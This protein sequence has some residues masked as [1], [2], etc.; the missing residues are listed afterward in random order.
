MV[1]PQPDYYRLDFSILSFP[2]PILLLDGKSEVH[3]HRQGELFYFL[4]KTK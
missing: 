1:S 3:V 2:C 4:L